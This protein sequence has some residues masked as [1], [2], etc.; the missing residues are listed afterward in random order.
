MDTN[1]LVSK[2][3]DDLKPVRPLP[4]AKCCSLYWSGMAAFLAAVAVIV[5]GGVRP[6]FLEATRRPVFLF[7]NLAMLAA[8]LLSASIAFQLRVPQAIVSRPIKTLLASASAIWIFE[9]IRRYLKAGDLASEARL[10]FAHYIHDCLIDLTLM[11]AIP[12]AFMF[13]MLKKGATTQALWAGYAA[14]LATASFAALGMR[15]LCPV[16]DPA[17]LLVWHFMPVLAYAVIGPVAGRY[18]LR[19]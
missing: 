13:F 1:K 12:A 8:G 7:E 15:Y 9:I 11:M 3:V 4:S 5:L 14:L 19:W 17:H 16:D 18:F 2:L 10:D 6:D